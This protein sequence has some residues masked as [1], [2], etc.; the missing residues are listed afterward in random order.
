MG[1][2]TI[3]VNMGEGDA[4]KTQS[5]IMV[6]EKLCKVADK[7]E[8]KESSRDQAIHALSELNEGSK[9]DQVKLR[10]ICEVVTINKVNVG[11]ASDG[12]TREAVKGH[13][14]YFK[15]NGCSI[16]LIAGRANN[17][18]V[19]LLKDF[20]DRNEYRLW[21]TSNARIYEEATH[22]RVA[23]KGML[24]RFYEQ[25]AEEIANLI[26]SWCYAEK[27]EKEENNK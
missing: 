9:K 16:M 25:W 18:M 1:K 21:R 26:E 20:A 2:G 8:G 5:I 6:Y 12:D 24:K 4:G 22:P 3:I 10:D 19:K 15:S 23:P 17:P 11:I 7:S 27:A 13:L 14:E